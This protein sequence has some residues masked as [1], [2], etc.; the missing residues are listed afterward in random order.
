M[1]HAL[2]QI[3]EAFAGPFDSHFERRY[4][5]SGDFGDLFVTHLFHVLQKESF[6]LFNRQLRERFLDMLAHRSIGIFIR[7]GYGTLNEIGIRNESELSSALPGC[8]RPAFIHDDLIQPTPKPFAISTARE[9]AICTHESRLQHI[10]SIRARAQ[11]A[12]RE[13]GADITV[14]LE[15][16]TE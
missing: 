5:D 10:V 13:P 2:E 14:P 6:T 15:K 8:K 1:V 3:T 12:N 11:H 7:V 9:V 16:H 4:T